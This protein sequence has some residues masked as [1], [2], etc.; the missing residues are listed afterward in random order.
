MTSLERFGA[1]MF[2]VRCKG[3][4][5]ALG[6]KGNREGEEGGNFGFA[7]SITVANR[8]IAQNLLSDDVGIV[9]GLNFESAVV[10]PQVDRDIDASN[11]A[12][13]NLISVSALCWARE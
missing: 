2:R 3:E 10:G 1:A 13:V 12:L 5:K 6:R 11:T 4:G 9:A 8:L 7:V